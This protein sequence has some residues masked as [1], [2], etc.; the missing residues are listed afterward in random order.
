[1]KSVEEIERQLLALQ[2]EYSERLN[3]LQSAVNYNYYTGCLDTIN[4]V[5]KFINYEK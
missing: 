5:L 2:E 4:I 3:D 1:M